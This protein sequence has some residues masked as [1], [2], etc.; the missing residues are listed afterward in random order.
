MNTKQLS[1][2]VVAGLMLAGL[3]VTTAQSVKM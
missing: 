1:A 2:V 3:T